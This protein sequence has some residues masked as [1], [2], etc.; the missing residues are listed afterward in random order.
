MVYCLSIYTDVLRGSLKGS[1]RADNSE[2]AV[3]LQDLK[4]PCGQEEVQRDT[5]SVRCEG[6]H[7]A[8]LRRTPGHAGPYQEPADA[9][10]IKS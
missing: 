2:S 7:R 8:V 1:P 9:V 5:T 3:F 10:C 6:R 4:V